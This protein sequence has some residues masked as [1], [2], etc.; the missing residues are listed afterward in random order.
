MDT[1]NLRFEFPKKS[2]RL[3]LKILRTRLEK[4]IRHLA[5]RFYKSQEIE[6]APGLLEKIVKAAV[7]DLVE[8]VNTPNFT[9]EVRR[10]HVKDSE[11][12]VKELVADVRSRAAKGADPFAFT[13]AR[14]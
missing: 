10:P 2:R 4:N 14:A 1:N 6:V 12:L 5:I 7:N 13:K 11:S 8:A 9:S 3:R